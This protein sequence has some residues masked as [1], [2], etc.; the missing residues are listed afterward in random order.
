LSTI[1]T[2]CLSLLWRSASWVIGSHPVL[3]GITSRLLQR[4]IFP[5][6]VL[7]LLGF[8]RTPAGRRLLLLDGQFRH[9]GLAKNFHLNSYSPEL[10][11]VRRSSGWLTLSWLPAA[12]F[13]EI[14]TD[15]VAL[16]DQGS[17]SGTLDIYRSGQLRYCSSQLRPAQ[18]RS[19]KGKLLVAV[20]GV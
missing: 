19:P 2:R 5:P 8:K 1:W 11:R 13:L 16:E 9:T 17:K 6:M 10:R 3:R 18:A 4:G 12:S 7:P 14:S 20:L 15:T